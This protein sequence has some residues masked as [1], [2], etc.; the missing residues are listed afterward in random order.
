MAVTLYHEFRRY[1]YR[2]NCHRP[3]HQSQFNYLYPILSSSFT[4]IPHKYQDDTFHCQ[5]K[6]ITDHIPAN[7][8]VN[9]SLKV[10][11]CLLK[12]PHLIGNAKIIIY[13]P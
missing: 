5:L 13:Q 12:L 11:F 8:G 1:H 9:V 2:F 4:S 10:G 3:N 6:L 7:T